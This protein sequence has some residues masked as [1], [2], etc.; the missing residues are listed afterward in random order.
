MVKKM[1]V[2]DRSVLAVRIAR[3]LR[4]LGVRYAVVHSEADVSL[5]YTRKSPKAAQIGEARPQISYLRQEAI[6]NA[7]P[8]T[9]CDAIHSGYGFLSESA[10]LADKV[11]DGDF[12]FIGPEPRHIAALGDKARAREIMVEAGFPTMPA[13]APFPDDGTPRRSQRRS[14]TRF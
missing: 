4:R 8:R 13:S 11:V 2:A 9:G 1:L 5:P 14:D 3:T 12:T 6:L 10:Q 7:A